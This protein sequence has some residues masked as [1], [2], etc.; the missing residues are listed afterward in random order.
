MGE[1]STVEELR[2]VLAAYKLVKDASWPDLHPAMAKA[3]S[4]WGDLE[5]S[6]LRAE[7]E[8][9]V[10]ETEVPGCEV[11]LFWKSG[12][13]LEFR[14][15]NRNFAKDAGLSGP[16]ELI[17]LDDFS[18]KLP[19]V[20]QAAKYRADDKE[21][22][23]GSQAKLDILERQK[24]S[25]GVVWVLVGKAPIVAGGSSVGILGMY[26]VLDRETGHKLFGERAREG[27]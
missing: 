13:N 5:E 20:A 27:R 2:G 18:D 22:V 26:Q 17:G 24:S 14:G 3:S 21:V 8:G 25:S 23:D 15:C 10:A 1:P 6:G 7:L 9:Y 12:P 4:R 16:Q 11:R 19:W